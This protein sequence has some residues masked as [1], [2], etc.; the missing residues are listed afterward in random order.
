[1]VSHGAYLDKGELI[2]RLINPLSGQVLD[3]VTAPIDGFLFTIR[4]YPVVDEGSLI[5]RILRREAYE[6]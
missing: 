3:E 6:S 1:E 2:G 5:G 4:D